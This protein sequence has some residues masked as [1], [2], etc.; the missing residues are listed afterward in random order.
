[1][2]IICVLWL[3]CKNNN[4]FRLYEKVLNLALLNLTLKRCKC[5][6]CN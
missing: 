2:L 4:T 5:L 1:M 3:W 6:V